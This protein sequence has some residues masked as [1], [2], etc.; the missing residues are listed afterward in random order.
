MKKK[1]LRNCWATHFNNITFTYF[2]KVILLSYV[3]A[4]TIF[5]LLLWYEPPLPAKRLII[6]QPHC[7]YINRVLSSTRRWRFLNNRNANLKPAW[8][9][10]RKFY[11]LGSRSLF[12]RRHIIIIYTF[13]IMFMPWS[14]CSNYASASSVKYQCGGCSYYTHPHPL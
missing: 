14:S 3:Y 8:S 5:I 4:L 12:C 1:S 6:K 2:L 10:F 13:G 7:S 9:K 11:L